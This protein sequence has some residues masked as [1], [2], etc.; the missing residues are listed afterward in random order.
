MEHCA[1]VG[2]R[3]EAPFIVQIFE[4]ALDVID[5]DSVGRVLGHLAGEAL[6]ECIEANDEVGNHLRLARRAD[7]NR[8]HPGE[9]FIVAR[10][11]ADQREDPGSVLHLV[12]DLIALRRAEP[13]LHLGC[14]AT[15]P[16]PD[17]AWAWR[18]GER[19]VVALNLSDA[20]V[21][22]D[23]VRGTVAVSAD[24]G[25]DGERIDGSLELGGWDGVVVAG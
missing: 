14:Y 24:R 20:P 25:R 10:N 22:V 1:A 6:L 5:L 11:V 2:R 8:N 3:R 19:H 7:P 18:R 21:V 13:D 4:R 17:G 16:A 12:R 15:L 9:K 23:G